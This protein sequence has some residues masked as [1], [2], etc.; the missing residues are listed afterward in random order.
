M[1][2]DGRYV[3]NESVFK[4]DAYAALKSKFSS[5]HHFDSFYDSLP[6]DD[7]KDSFLR[8]SCFYLY[9]VKCGDWHIESEK[10]DSVIDYLTNSY[11]LVSLFSLIE[12]LSDERHQDFYEW[13]KSQNPDDTFPIQNTKRLNQ[14]YDQYKRSFGSIRRCVR[15]FDRL[16]E[17]QKDNLCRSVNLNGQP[18]ESIKKLAAFLYDLRSKFVHEA[19]LI[20]EITDRTIFRTEKGLISTL[21]IDTILSSFEDGLIA[22][23]YESIDTHL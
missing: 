16:S 22:H 4:E 13:T 15:F 9:L 21:S 3:R 17:E 5:R 10:H 2:S 14:L 7:T 11:K 20:L 12:S 8:V 1:V 23:F 19:E 18:I 6:D